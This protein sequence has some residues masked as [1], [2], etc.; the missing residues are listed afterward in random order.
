M[1][2]LGPPARR[3]LVQVGDVL[4]GLSRHLP[5]PLLHMRRFALRN[6]LQYALPYVFE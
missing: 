4:Q 5:M 2:L 3:T 6:R 1:H